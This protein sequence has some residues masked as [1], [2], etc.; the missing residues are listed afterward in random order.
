MNRN[1]KSIKT[2]RHKGGAGSRKTKR[3]LK[4][5]GNDEGEPPVENPSGLGGRSTSFSSRDHL[6]Q[7]EVTFL[8]EY[9]Y[10]VEKGTSY[11]GRAIRK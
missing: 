7:A 9:S 10:S 8:Q 4:P 1:L 6:L 5:T 2:G 3:S 11:R